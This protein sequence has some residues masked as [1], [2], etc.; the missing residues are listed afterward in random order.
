MNEDLIWAGSQTNRTLSD[1]GRFDNSTGI[2]R[3]RC[4]P[5]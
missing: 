4:V 2:V 1:W 3:I 5:A